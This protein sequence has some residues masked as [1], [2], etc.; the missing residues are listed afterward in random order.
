[1][2]RSK[3]LKGKIKIL[4]IRYVKDFHQK[5][6]NKLKLS[7]IIMKTSFKVSGNFSGE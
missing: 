7:S 6:K 4:R 3:S 1:M 2:K 5:L